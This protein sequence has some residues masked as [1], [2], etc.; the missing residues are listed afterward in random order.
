[1]TRKPDCNAMTSRNC[2]I[3]SLSINNRSSSIF[4]G[5]KAKFQG[6][7]RWARTTFHFKFAVKVSKFAAGIV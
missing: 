6:I 7:D 5:R 2:K 3:T 1:M 4:A